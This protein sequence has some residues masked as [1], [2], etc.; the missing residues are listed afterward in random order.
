MFVC[1]CMCVYVCVCAINHVI[2]YWKSCKVP[3]FVYCNAKVIYINIMI[4]VPVSPDALFCS[5]HFLVLSLSVAWNHTV[6]C[7]TQK[8]IMG[9]P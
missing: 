6:H 4:S 1:V 5:L 3:C 2:Q 9:A 7:V 8:V